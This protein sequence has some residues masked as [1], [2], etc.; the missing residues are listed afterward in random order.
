MDPVGLRQ[1][2]RDYSANMS[3]NAIRDLLIRYDVGNRERG[4]Q[5]IKS[6]HGTDLVQEMLSR[7]EV[8]NRVKARTPRP[9]SRT[10]E[11]TR[12]T[13]K[14]DNAAPTTV[15]LSAVVE[16]LQEEVQ[17]KETISPTFILP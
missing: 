15:D 12:K 1:L 8:S 13:R 9:K 2:C 7:V 4:K 6:I 10:S 11:E 14:E 3:V 5:G 17:P 16:Q